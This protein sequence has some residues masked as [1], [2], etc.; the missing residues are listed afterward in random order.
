MEAGVLPQQVSEVKARID[1]RRIERE[2]AL[3]CALG[4]SRIVAAKRRPEERPRTGILP[5]PRQ[6]LAA[7]RN[8]RACVAAPQSLPR[9]TRLRADAQPA[10]ASQNCARARID[11]I[12]RGNG[13][14]ATAISC[15]IGRRACSS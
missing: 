13:V 1:V 8:S 15:A 2:R 11:A 12:G 10:A 5:V 9:R 14:D 3:E 4:L 7:K 6:R